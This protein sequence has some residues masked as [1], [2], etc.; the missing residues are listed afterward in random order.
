MDFNNQDTAVVITDP[1]NDFLSPDGVIWGLVGA[2]VE[3][4]GTVGHI[5]DL[6]VAPK[7]RATTSS[8]RSTT[9]T[10]R[11]TVGSSAERLKR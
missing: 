3:E 1:Q 9:T 5:E 7:T 8:S 2:S 11:T 4:N 6:S 10:P